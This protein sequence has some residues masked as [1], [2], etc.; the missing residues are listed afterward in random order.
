MLNNFAKQFRVPK[1][2]LG[3][4]AGKIMFLENK[5]LNDWTIHQLSI[6]NG[7]TVLEIGFGPGY[8]I[9]KI[10]EGFI[11][12]RIEGIDL[13]EKMKEAATKKHEH[14]LETGK[15]KLWC[16]AVSDFNVE[17]EKYDRVFSVNNYPLWDN[18]QGTLEL[19]AR[20]LKKGG[21]MA[22]TVQPREKGDTDNTAKELAKQLEHDFYKAGL[23]NIHTSLK[24]VRP[25]LA[26]CVTGEKPH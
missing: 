3:K 14:L 11:D 24:K 21:K 23:I 13:S 6:T 2:L 9:D 25:T 20:S 15:L 5:K 7:Q 8:A 18:P 17:P 12:V 19:I 1:G 10:S 16:G 4:I 22:I 26:V